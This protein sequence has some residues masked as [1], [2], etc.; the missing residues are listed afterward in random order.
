[1]IGVDVFKAFAVTILPKHIESTAASLYATVHV[2]VAFL[3]FIG[4]VLVL[5]IPRVPVWNRSATVMLCVI[6]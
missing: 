1:M 4:A 5:M 3:V 6:A 2:I